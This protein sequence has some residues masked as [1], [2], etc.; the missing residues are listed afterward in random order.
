MRPAD[1]RCTYACR[2]TIGPFAANPAGP[3]FVLLHGIGLSHRSFSRL[4]RQLGPA[5]RVVAFDLPGF[6]ATPRPKRRLTVEDHAALVGDRL[7]RMDLGPVVLVGHS[8]GAQFAVALAGQRPHQVERV[9]LIG[10]VVNENRRTLRDQAIG[11]LRDSLLEPPATQ[12]MVVFDYLRCGVP[13]FLAESVAMRDYPIE[14]AI[15]EIVQP[16]LIVRGENDPI[17][18][19][20]WCAS[21]AAR[22]RDGRVVTIPRH[23]HNVLYSGPEATA[24]AILAFS[25]VN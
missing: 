21:L 1:H 13:W 7:D 24:A 22:S 25:E 19:A 12:L 2:V 6:G 14:K 9:V 15:T 4:A 10:P 8:M 3:V 23:R 11:L 20:A 5:N 17:A 18:N 16:V